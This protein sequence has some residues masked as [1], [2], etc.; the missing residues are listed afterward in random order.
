VLAILDA[1]YSDTASAVACVTA[2]GGLCKAAL[3]A[4]ALIDP[5]W[6]VEVDADTVAARQGL[7]KRRCPAPANQARCAFPGEAAVTIRFLA[8]AMACLMAAPSLAQTTPER[9]TYTA[10][11]GEVTQI[12]Q[13]Q[14]RHWTW[15]APAG[16]YLATAKVRYSLLASAR[17]ERGATAAAL[18]ELSCELSADGMQGGSDRSEANQ[19]TDQATATGVFSD[20]SG[21]GEFNLVASAGDNGSSSPVTVTLTCRNDTRSTNPGSTVSVHQIAVYLTPISGGLMSMPLVPQRA[22]PA[23]PPTPKPSGGSTV[24]PPTGSTTS[25]TPKLQ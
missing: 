15:T 8:A 22:Q 16:G 1:A 20:S 5:D 23:S 12:A 13:G 21:K 7:R 24:K 6:L 19:S 2:E 3:G 17:T 25:T 4:N 14:Q 10:K 9:R 18:A 11:V